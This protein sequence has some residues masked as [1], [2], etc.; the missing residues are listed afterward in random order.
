MTA[1]RPP[2]TLHRAVV[3]GLGAVT[4]IGN[5]VDEFWEGLHSGRNGI[6]RGYR[7]LSRISHEPLGPEIQARERLSRLE[8]D[9]ARGRAQ[10]GRGR[11]RR[12]RLDHARYYR[13]FRTAQ[14][15]VPGNARSGRPHAERTARHRPCAFRERSP[16]A[17]AVLRSRR[18]RPSVCRSA[19]RAGGG[20]TRP[21]DRPTTRQRMPRASWAPRR[22]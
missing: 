2:R 19:R 17:G 22:P 9:L 5:T 10:G 8:R 11:V 7:D 14:H 13:P 4:P 15:P 12:P 20:W 18:H 3:T 16:S 1:P 21:R 6:G